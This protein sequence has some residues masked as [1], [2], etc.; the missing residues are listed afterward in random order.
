MST[1][2][3]IRH[4]PL[5]QLSLSPLNV[6]KI[7]AESGIEELAALIRAQGVLQNLMVYKED[8]PRGKS[9][10]YKVVAGGRRWRALKQLAK[11]GDIHADYLVPCQIVGYERAEEISLAE[12]SGREAMHPADQFEAFRKLTESGQSVE[13]VAARF[14]VSP[15]VVQRRLKLANV[16]PQLIALYRDGDL[17][18]EHLMAFA[19][20]E[21]HARQQ[22]VWASLDRY[23]RSPGA[24]RRALTEG[25]TSIRDAV[26]RF[27]GVKV[28]E[29]AGGHI[30]RDLFAEQDDG[31][32]VDAELLTRLATE[33]LDKQAAA[34]KAEGLAWV[35]VMRHLDY[36]ELA[37]YGRVRQVLREPTKKEQ[38]RLTGLER[39]RTALE[40]QVTEAERAGDEERLSRLGARA[41]ALDSAIEQINEG[42]RVP[43]P[44]Q[45]ARAGAVI[46]IG[47]DGKLRVERDLL[48]PGETGTGSADKRVGTSD[49]DEPGAPALHSAALVRRLTA[50]RTAAL[51]IML[52]RSAD[53]ALAALTHSL[54]LPIFYG[55]GAGQSAVQVQ[56]QIPAL[57]EHGADIGSCRAIG[58]LEARR[59]E[60]ASVLPKDA[61]ML[62][63]WLLARPQAEVLSVLAFCVAVSVNTVQSD[64]RPGTFD[65]LARAVGLDMR[66][67]WTPTVEAYFGSIPKARILAV[68]TEAISEKAAVP[69]AKLKKA[70]LAKAAEDCVTVTT[71]LPEPLRTV[72]A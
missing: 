30:R 32:I 58:A 49:E 62:L 52:A 25:E 6:R 70:D 26:A 1:Q 42:R 41:G 60:F 31:F 15:L 36:S 57:R 17:T 53:A 20:T 37:A 64:E 71:W 67:W 45:Q 16:C 18:L 8:K 11:N 43:D 54:A 38:T 40:A 55:Q 35:E 51:Q 10:G 66:A 48:R 47:Q 24:I 9:A 63:D 12:N 68:V 7:G 34:L 13:D 29:K 46:A 19:V 33:K 69:L 2:Q 50:H 59:G 5:K 4:L 56:T 72:A 44:A 28:Y 22:Q 27:V 21:D 23:N 65:R 3:S 14:G 61:E 39:R